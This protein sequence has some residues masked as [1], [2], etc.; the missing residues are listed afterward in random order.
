MKMKK[1]WKRVVA[2][3]SAVTMGDH[4][5]PADHICQGILA[6][7]TVRRSKERYR[8]GSQYGNNSI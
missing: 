3:L 6:E 5:N 7:G 8:H 2:A 4:R 1:T